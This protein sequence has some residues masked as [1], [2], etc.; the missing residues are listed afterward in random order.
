MKPMTVESIRAA[1]RGLMVCGSRE[2]EVTG[3]STDTRSI[4]PGDLFVALSGERYDGHDFIRDALAVGACGAVYSRDFPLYRQDANHTFIK[5]SDTLT[6]LGDIARAYR[7]SLQAAVVGITGSNGKTTTKEMVRHLLEEKLS[8]VASPASFNNFVGVPLTIFSADA[9]TAVIV[10]EMGTNRPGEIARLAQIAA[11]GM[12]VITN[13]GRSHLEG[14]GSKEGVARAKAELLHELTDD[15]VAIL[16]ADDDEVIK[17]GRLAPRVVTFGVGED[18]DV[19][20]AGIARTPSGFE[21]LLNGAARTELNVPGRQ[22]I[23]NALAAIAVCRRLGV[24][25]EYL[26]ERLGSFRLPAMRLE[27]R[28]IRG[29]L[30]INDAYNANPESVSGAIEELLERK[31]KRKFLVFADMLELG[32]HSPQLHRDVGC[33]AAGA[34]LDFCWVTGQE[35]LHCV[36]GARESGM[37]EEFA[38]FFPTLESLAD[39]LRRTICEGDIVL[40]K[41][42]RGMC[43]ERLFELLK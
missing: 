35:A 40:V 37:S 28:Q 9:S 36:E 38:A 13:V 14:F 43:L 16:N 1:T 8:T 10:I 34:G 29:A 31:G 2:H 26:A 41:A 33:M 17:M 20:A 25:L 4:A 7:R 30:V 42:S 24:E 19:F 27:E 15:G 11:P 39:A 6:A 12:G 21:F 22:N 32:E 23:H 5:V 3:I 18:A